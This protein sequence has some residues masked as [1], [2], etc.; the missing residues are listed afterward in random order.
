MALQHGATLHSFQSTKVLCR[1]HDG[2]RHAARHLPE[3]L[4]QRGRV[5]LE[6]VDGRQLLRV[7]A[8]HLRVELVERHLRALDHGL[9]LQLRGGFLAWLSAK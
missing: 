5:F 9:Q 1:D 2:L 6:R 3:R 8:L 7:Q 4:P